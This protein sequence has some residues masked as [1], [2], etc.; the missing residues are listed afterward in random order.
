MDAHGIKFASRQRCKKAKVLKVGFEPQPDGSE[1]LRATKTTSWRRTTHSETDSHYIFCSVLRPEAVTTRYKGLSKSLTPVWRSQPSRRP[2]C[3]APSLPPAP[4]CARAD[5]PRF[6]RALTAPAVPYA[7]PLLLSP[8]L[9]PSGPTLGV[10]RPTRLL[11]HLLGCKVFSH[12]LHGRRHVTESGH[13]VLHGRLSRHDRQ[14]SAVRAQPSRA[15]GFP[16]SSI[17]GRLSDRDFVEL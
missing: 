3:G 16:W 8:C 11:H 5:R 12:E 4:A 17:I 9:R 6:A 1:D 14:N 10:S 2:S 13:L 7:L 15:C